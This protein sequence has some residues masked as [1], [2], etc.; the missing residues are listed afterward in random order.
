M[1]TSPLVITQ[2]VCKLC[3]KAIPE[4]VPIVGEPPDN[5]RRRK[6]QQM[7]VHMQERH[8]V[9]FQTAITAGIVAGQTIP[10]ILLAADFD[11]PEDMEKRRQMER[12]ELAKALRRVTLTDEELEKLLQEAAAASPLSRDAHTDMDAVVEFGVQVLKILRDRYEEIGE[13]GPEIAK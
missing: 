9:A 4:G 3:G 12:A 7:T 10:A 11:L 2:I 5:V 8:P 13:Y 1:S 6:V